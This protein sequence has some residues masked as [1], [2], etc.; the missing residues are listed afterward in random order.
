MSEQ[1]NNN[2]NVTIMPGIPDY[3]EPC[4]FYVKRLDLNNMTILTLDNK[5][6]ALLLKKRMEIE[7]YVVHIQEPDGS[8]NITLHSKVI[9][10][11]K[12]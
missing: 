8:S 12:I 2:Y 4:K 3:V 1:S 10:G 9:N 11:V 5:I 7:G 6:S